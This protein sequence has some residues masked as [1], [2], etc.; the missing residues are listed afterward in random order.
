MYPWITWELVMDPKRSLLESLDYAITVYDEH[1]TRIKCNL[2][3]DEIMHLINLKVKY[4][5]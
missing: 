1:G 4:L 3:I 2:L 5:A